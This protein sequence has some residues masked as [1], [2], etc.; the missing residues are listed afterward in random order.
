MQGLDK[1]IL[2]L[3][4]IYSLCSCRGG[5]IEILSEFQCP[6]LLMFIRRGGG[7][8]SVLDEPHW[9]NVPGSGPGGL[10][11]PVSGLRFR[12]AGY[13]PTRVRT[14]SPAFCLQNAAPLKRSVF[15]LGLHLFFRSSISQYSVK[16]K[17]LKLKVSN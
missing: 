1:N 12:V 13:V 7:D 14:S 4:P 16:G 17:V 2:F 5:W 10:A 11:P 15:Q 9:S 6:L 8:S 3:C